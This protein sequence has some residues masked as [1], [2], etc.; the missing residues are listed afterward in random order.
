MRRR[1]RRRRRARTAARHVDAFHDRGHELRL[2][3]SSS[4]KNAVGV[5]LSAPLRRAP[6]KI[7]WAGRARPMVRRVERWTCR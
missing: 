2:C 5:A 3:Y 7:R 1:R 4:F 6:T